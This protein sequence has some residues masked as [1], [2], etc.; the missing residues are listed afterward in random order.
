MKSIYFDNAAS[1]GYKPDCVKRLFCKL[2]K[3]PQIQAGAGTKRLWPRRLLSPMRATIRQNFGAE[4]GNVVFTY[5]CTAALNFAIFGGISGDH[6]VTTAFEHNSVLRPLDYLKRSGVIDY[7]VVYPDSSGVI[8]AKE[9]LDKI[10]R[11]TKMIIVNHVSNVTGARAIEEI[12]Y[13]ADRYG[14]PFLV[15]AAQS[16]GHININMKDTKIN[17]LA[18]AGHKGL[19]APQGVGVWLWLKALRSD[20]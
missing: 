5:N 17:I 1:G 3:T 12:G 10:R 2:W 19:A 20:L 15:D 9:F 8:R 4:G 14:I 13:C 6:V 16:A 7:T 18:A 11:D